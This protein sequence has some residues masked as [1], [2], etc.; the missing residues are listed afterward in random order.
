[1]RNEQLQKF[2]DDF[3]IHESQSIH[4]NIVVV[5]DFNIT[6]WSSYYTILEDV[7]SG[8]MT[9]ITKYIPFLFTRKL[10]A[11]PFVQAHIDHLWITPTLTILS[12]EKIFIPGSDH[13]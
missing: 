5:G 6:P 4:K 3:N 11:L 1:M 13:K 10:F 8:K 9:N 12:I 7:F 2:V